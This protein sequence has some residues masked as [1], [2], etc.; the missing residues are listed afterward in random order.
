MLMLPYYSRAAT[1]DTPQAGEDQPA[2]AYGSL[3]PGEVG[4]QR[5]KRVY[6]TDGEIGRVEGLVREPAAREHRS[7]QRVATR[8]PTPV[9]TDGGRGHRGQVGGSTSFSTVRCERCSRSAT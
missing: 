5:D 7:P 1:G 2:G 3:P 4:V 6:A 9:G 8:Q